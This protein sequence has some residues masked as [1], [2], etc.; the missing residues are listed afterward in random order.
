MRDIQEQPAINRLPVDPAAL[1]A[2]VATTGMDLGLTSG[3]RTLG[4]AALFS[5]AAFFLGYSMPWFVVG[6]TQAG[7][8]L[9]LLHLMRRR[10]C[11]LLI[12]HRLIDKFGAARF[13][14][15]QGWVDQ[16]NRIIEEI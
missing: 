1:V 2:L 13:G 5:A 11:Q 7:I 16:A 15:A 14:A 12:C 8:V 6:V 10:H 3:I 4:L 9:G